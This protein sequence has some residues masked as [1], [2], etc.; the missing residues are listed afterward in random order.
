MDN[1]NIPQQFQGSAN[2][3]KKIIIYVGLGLAIFIAIGFLSAYAL[4]K[5]SYQRTDGISSS[6]PEIYAYNTESGETADVTSLGGV[7]LLQRNTASLLYKDGKAETIVNSTSKPLI[8]GS[9]DVHIKTPS[10]AKLVS[11]GGQTC[12]LVLASGIYSYSCSQPTALNKHAGIGQNSKV[13]EFGVVYPPARYR[14]GFLAQQYVQAG[15]QGR[16]RL[17][18]TLTYVT[19]DKPAVTKKLSGELYNSKD[20]NEVF[21]DLTDPKSNVFVVYNHNTGVG[22]YYDVFD[23]KAAGTEFKRQYELDSTSE[24]SSCSLAD[25]RFVCFHG[26]AGDP[27][28][29]VERTS[30]E[31]V[32]KEIA[33]NAKLKKPGPGMV[34]VVDFSSLDPVNSLYKGPKDFGLSKLYMTANGDIFGQQGYAIEHIKLQGSS[35]T[36]TPITLNATAIAAGQ[37]L[38]FVHNNKL[39]EYDQTTDSSVLRYSDPNEI[40]DSLSMYG[41]QLL[42]LSY[43]QKDPAQLLNVYQVEASE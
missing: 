22:R 34:E 43:N 9:R 21:T 38:T 42:S 40:I 4:I 13:S 11:S 10:S 32:D 15:S 25:K 18:H 31:D 17:Y 28:H 33:A 35:F 1:M 7:L 26:P 29:A 39:F 20:Y 27:T 41:S 37:T 5:P 12:P 19:P 23:D 16:S 14:D 36:P 30:L 8:Y 3:R 6:Q 2:L 24:Q